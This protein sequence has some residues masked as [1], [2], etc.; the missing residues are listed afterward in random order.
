MSS[1]LA[2]GLVGLSAAR[3]H[4]SDIYS[5]IRVTKIPCLEAIIIIT[6]KNYLETLGLVA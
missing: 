1:G 4:V 6:M 5:Q 2:S 3:K